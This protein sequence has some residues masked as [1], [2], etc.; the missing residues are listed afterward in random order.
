M[1]S[2]H[3][4]IAA[5][6]PSFLFS[7]SSP[8]SFAAASVASAWVVTKPILLELLLLASSGRREEDAFGSPASRGAH[9]DGLHPG[10]LQTRN[11]PLNLFHHPKLFFPLSSYASTD[12]SLSL[13]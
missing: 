7:S 11:L 13:S 6:R 8:C 4:E 2:R 3:K 5:F 9:P 10:A 12:P 1:E